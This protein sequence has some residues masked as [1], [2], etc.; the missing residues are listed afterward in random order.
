MT[1][2]NDDP[3]TTAWVTAQTWALRTVLSQLIEHLGERDDS[4]AE[5]LSRLHSVRWNLP[6]IVEG[7]VYSS[8]EPDMQDPKAADL[9]VR[10][11]QQAYE[12][13]LAALPK[14]S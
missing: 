13:M 2:E 9:T 5:L 7:L 14:P 3:I 8:S 4:I 12:E 11:F 6:E 10:Y 1:I